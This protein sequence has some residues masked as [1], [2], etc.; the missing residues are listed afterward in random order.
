MLFKNLAIATLFA[1]VFI[2]IGCGSATRL[3]NIQNTPVTTSSGKTSNTENVRRVIILA[4]T[5][6]GWQMQ[7][8]GLGHIVATIFQS[9]HM[10]KVDINYSGNSYNILYKDSNNLSYNGTTIH[11]TYNRW[12]KRLDRNIR[13][14]LAN[15]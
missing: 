1:S 9:G 5:R 10:A 3:L 2:V 4:G 7:D 15:L 11:K 14:G 6:V 8:A 13:S 12:V